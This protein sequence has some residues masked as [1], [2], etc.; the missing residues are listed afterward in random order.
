MTAAQLSPE[1]RAAI[2]EAARRNVAKA[3]PPKAWQIAVL[4]PL[5]AGF[6]P[7][8]ARREAA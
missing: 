2:R 8:A 1:V 3:P 7:R 5:F 4:A 6:N